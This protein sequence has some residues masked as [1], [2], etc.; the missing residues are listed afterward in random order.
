MKDRIVEA[1]GLLRGPLWPLVF[2]GSGVATAVAAPLAQAGSFG[3]L[4]GV[5]ALTAIPLGL[6]GTVAR[7]SYDRK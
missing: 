5:A 6:V 1:K 3:A 4:F 7:L 2:A